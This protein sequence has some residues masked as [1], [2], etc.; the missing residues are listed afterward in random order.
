MVMIISFCNETC[1]LF[2]LFA[3]QRML[4]FEFPFCI[5]VCFSLLPAFPMDICRSV[6][7]ILQRES[8]YSV[9]S[10]IA[11]KSYSH[12]TLTIF[13]FHRGE[14]IGIRVSKQNGKFG[15]FWGFINPKIEI[16]VKKF[17]ME[18]YMI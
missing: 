17:F 4:L 18:N 7:L 14:I 6:A 2:L 8:F 11:C 10:P 16:V 9:V 3:F 13:I 5:H 1:L 15:L 12:I